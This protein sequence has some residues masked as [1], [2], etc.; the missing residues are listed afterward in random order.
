M[1][2]SPGQP[3]A[4]FRSSSLRRSIVGVCFLA[5][6]PPIAYAT[7]PATNDSQTVDHIQ[8]ILS[9]FATL[10]AHHWP[11]AA[12]LLGGCALN[13]LLWGTL[14][15]AAGAMFSIALYLLLRRRGWFDA[16]WAWYRRWRWAWG[17]IL[18]GCICLGAAG[19]G[20]CLGLQ[21]QL[22]HAI[23]R[24]HVLDRVVGNIVIA[25]YMDAADYRATG[26]ETAEHVQQ[27]IDDSNAVAT[28]TTQDL[29]TL[30]SQLADRELTG[31]R[32]YAFR[33]FGNKYVSEKIDELLDIDPRAALILFLTPNI[34]RY[35]RD[36]P[37]AQIGVVMFSRHLE[38]LRLLAWRGVNALILPWLFTC[39]AIGLGVP[40]TLLIA[41][42]IAVRRT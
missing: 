7:K 13:M 15:L 24:E 25:L 23:V 36:H 1:D 39:L 22:H 35:L 9:N 33:W 10:T 28:L 30:F 8:R 11:D 14:L 6:L 17:V 31:W 40:F 34:D 3:V 4:R 32:R 18:I 5:S 38:H 21:R 26:D 20:V 12:K 37:D 2:I 27:I 16:P 29:H 41:L 19:T 42:R